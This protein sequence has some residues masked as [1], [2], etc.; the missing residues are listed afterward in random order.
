V[1]KVYFFYH[2]FPVISSYHLKKEC[3]D[4]SNL[5]AAYFKVF[6]IAIFPPRHVFLVVL[7]FIFT[8]QFK[9]QGQMTE[10]CYLEDWTIM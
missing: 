5:P 1:E 3:A 2:C 10:P 7:I 9:I 8:L 6:N 4:V